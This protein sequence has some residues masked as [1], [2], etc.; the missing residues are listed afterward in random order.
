M[1][2]VVIWSGVCVHNIAKDLIQL[3]RWSW[4]VCF[5][6]RRFIRD[7][8]RYHDQIFCTASIF[9]EKLLLLEQYLQIVPTAEVLTNTRSNNVNSNEIV[10]HILK[11]SE[12]NYVN[13]S[14]SFYDKLKGMFVCFLVFFA[15]SATKKCFKA[16]NKI[17]VLFCCDLR[18]VVICFASIIFL[19]SVFRSTLCYIK[20]ETLLLLKQAHENKIIPMIICLLVSG[21]KKPVEPGY[22][23]FHIRR[24][25]FQQKHTRWVLFL[26]FGLLVH[27]K[28]D[29]WSRYAI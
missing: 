13:N 15:C 29:L 20:D 21:G 28:C 10:D 8:L 26:M 14:W 22:V 18:C 9:I 1:Y 24:G 7:R 6:S 25:D 23:A 4:P 16:I 27:C 11:Y 17:N 12:G 19:K 2:F 3:F 5:I